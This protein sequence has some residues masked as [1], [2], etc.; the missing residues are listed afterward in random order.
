[1]DPLSGV[2]SLLR[3][4]NYHSATLRLGGDWAFNFPAN[5][6]IKFTAVASG[7]C[8]LSVN[9]QRPAV[10]LQQGDCFLMTRGMPFTL[11]S[12]TSLPPIDG[13]GYF[14]RLSEDEISL[15][16]GG[17]DVQLVGGRFEFSGMPT[18]VLLSTL[19]ALVHV[20]E[21]S[22]QAS[23]LRWALQR[24]TAELHECRPGRSLMTEH[25][26]HIMLVEVMRTHMTTINAAE[27][28]WFSGLADRNLSNAM[29]AI[30][31]Q[32]A[33]RWSVETLARQANMSR[34]AFAQRFKDVVG[35]APMEYLT[36]WRMLL[37]SDRLKNTSDSVSSIA[38]SLGYESESA[39]STAFKR[40]MSQSPRQYQ[41]S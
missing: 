26:A 29:S 23:I 16:H 40:V 30:H 3:V 5:E 2:L 31:A 33:E 35:L 41:R 10:K 27:G 32:P 6:G 11:F 14:Q 39:F 15:S 20:R 18:Q 24:F 19:P 36:R 12:D 25:L 22:T 8:W 7:S 28:G 37:A 34:S 13:S 17:D 38:F 9:G 1:M 21:A 4:R